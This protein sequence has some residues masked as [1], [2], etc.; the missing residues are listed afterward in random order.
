VEDAP[1]STGSEER[2]LAAARVPY[3]GCG[4][5]LS[6]EKEEKWRRT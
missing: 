4:A 5:G 2:K 1:E 6:N 3:R